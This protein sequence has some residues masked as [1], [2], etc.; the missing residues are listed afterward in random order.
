MS[1]EIEWGLIHGEGDIVCSCDNC[2]T[3]E[4]F[5]F[6]DG[7]FDFKEVSQ[8]LRDYYGWTARKIGDEWYDFCCDSCFREFLSKKRKRG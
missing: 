1:K 2:D 8:E 7:C 5:P 4:Y 3:Q 6:E